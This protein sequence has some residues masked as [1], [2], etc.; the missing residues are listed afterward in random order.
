MR[1]VLYFLLAAGTAPAWA[2]WAK[3]GEGPESDAYVDLATIQ[4]LGNFRRVW[5]IQDMH[6]RNPDGA[7]S[8]R[9]F[10]E[11]DC[12]GKRARII[13]LSTHPEPMAVG[14]ALVSE[15]NPRPWA[16]VSLGTTGEAVL[17]IACKR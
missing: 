12:R 1:L 11:Y 14:A 8:S 10:T 7:M 3:L 17:D 15:D 4:R 13:S 2:Q 9:S 5:E 16:V 6:K